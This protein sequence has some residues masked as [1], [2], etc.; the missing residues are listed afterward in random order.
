VPSGGARDR[1]PAKGV[2]IVHAAKKR[3]GSSVGTARG[4]RR[5]GR[6]PGLLGH[7]AEIQC[8][9]RLTPMTVSRTVA[10]WPS[11]PVATR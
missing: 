7:V 6:I 10:D 4:N 1:L 11:G 9:R 8:A 2:R 5:G 3:H